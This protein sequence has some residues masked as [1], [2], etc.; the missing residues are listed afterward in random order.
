MRPAGGSTS[1][2]FLALFPLLPVRM[3]SAGGRLRASTSSHPSTSSPPSSRREPSRLNS[4]L[5]D[6]SALLERRLR[7]ER[8]DEPHR[9]RDQFPTAV[10]AN[11]LLA[12]AGETR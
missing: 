1:C 8:T 10:R 11:G 9:H 4:R 2:F 5:R 12:G 7:V 3:V 6:G